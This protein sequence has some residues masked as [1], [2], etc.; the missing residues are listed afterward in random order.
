MNLI[1]ES[2]RINFSANFAKPI[3]KMIKK[4]NVKKECFMKKRVLFLITLMF[5]LFSVNSLF[6][7]RDLN[8]TVVVC[9]STE[10]TPNSTSITWTFTIENLSPDGETITE[11]ILFFPDSITVTSS[12]DFSNVN[13]TPPPPFSLLSQG[14][15]GHSVNVSWSAAGLTSDPIPADSTYEATVTVDIA[16]LNGPLVIPWLLN[17]GGEGIP[18]HSAEGYIVMGPPYAILSFDL[19]TLPT[20]LGGEWIVGDTLC[21]EVLTQGE[22][23]TV[24]VDL[25]EIGGDAALQLD[26][27]PADS[28]LWTG[29]YIITD[30]HDD[31][32]TATITATAYFPAPADLYDTADIVLDIDN[33]L[34]EPITYGY[35]EVLDY[36]T[37]PDSNEIADWNYGNNNDRVRYWRGEENTG[38]GITWT[39][40]EGSALAVD[41][42]V[43]EPATQSHRAVKNGFGP[44]GGINWEMWDPG[45]IVSDNAGNDVIVHVEPDSLILL[46]NMMPINPDTTYFEVGQGPARLVIDPYAGIGDTIT[47]FVDFTTMAPIESGVFDFTPL[48]P[49]SP[50][51]DAAYLIPGIIDGNIM[52][53]EYV[54]QLGDVD[55]LPPTFPMGLIVEATLVDS[56][57]NFS[58][59]P[60]EIGGSTGDTL[61]VDGTIPVALTDI[62]NVGYLRF[63]P[64]TDSSLADYTT[65]T[66]MPDSLILE[67]VFDDW[68]VFGGPDEFVV[69]I[70]QENLANSREANPSALKTYKLGDPDVWIAPITRTAVAVQFSWNG[71]VPVG[72]E[73]GT[74]GQMA[75]EGTYGFTLVSML[76]GA[77]NEGVLGHVADSSDVD[78]AGGIFLLNAEHGV[79]DNTP[80]EYENELAVFGSDDTEVTV[81][82]RWIND[83]NY[84]DS[85]DTGDFLL[86][87]DSVYFQF[88]V[89]RQWEENDNP[90]R[91]ET[92]SYWIELEGPDS[93]KYRYFL[94]DE[95]DFGPTTAQYFGDA[96]TTFT[97]YLTVDDVVFGTFNEINGSVGAGKDIRWWPTLEGGIGNL[98]FPEGLYTITAK[99]RDN[100]GNIRD[101]Q[102]VVRAQV[103][104]IDMLYSAPV[105]DSL[106]IISE[107]TCPD[108]GLAAF[109]LDGN[110]NFYV[111]ASFD[112]LRE[113]YYYNS[114]D[115]FEVYLRLAD[116]T[117]LDSVVVENLYPI[118][119]HGSSRADIINGQLP[120]QVFYPGDFDPTN[121]D[122]TFSYDVAGI[123]ETAAWDSLYTV[124]YLNTAYPGLA[125]QVRVYDSYY[126]GEINFG[127]AL[128]DSFNLIRPEEPVWPGGDSY[129]LEVVLSDDRFSPGWYTHTYDAVDNPARDNEQDQVMI[130]LTYT[131]TE[132]TTRDF[133]WFL[134]I[135]TEPITSMT[136]VAFASAAFTRSGPVAFP[137]TSFSPTTIDFY[138]LANDI[139][140][141]PIIVQD[142]IGKLY[143]TAFALA[144]GYEDCGYDLPPALEMT[145]VIDTLWVDNTN[146][147]IIPVDSDELYDWQGDPN[148]AGHLFI[149]D[150]VVSHDKDNMIFRFR[151]DEPLPDSTLWTAVIVDENGNP[152][153]IDSNT[154]GVTVNEMLS[155]TAIILLQMIKLPTSNLKAIKNWKWMIHNRYSCWW[156]AS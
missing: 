72:S 130:D 91:D 128:A 60:I 118:V 54:V 140:D 74:P 63:S 36:D 77:D 66:N 154:I 57:G 55:Q 7:D 117:Y 94:G 71:I 152:L 144:E 116:I 103:E 104:L 155:D 127:A 27:D 122:L 80:P 86:E 124:G 143:V 135:D 11:V 18:E 81:I 32:P 15:T 75:P 93:T 138:G 65:L 6:A 43:V 25:T 48:N 33:E 85:L 22:A 153:V 131:F 133:T 67:I 109:D 150:M 148:Y 137:V 78:Y 149:E 14:Q 88:D 1:L 37:P 70:E 8:G 76:D 53:A 141:E 49:V 62:H 102:T 31:D 16:G 58:D 13:P 119:T 51:N 90:L 19:V 17:G 145:S 125:F 115:V 84:N 110:H 64:E 114:P 28:T 99:V 134:A 106:V 111:D 12:T 146:P 69:R 34:P 35:F 56:A 123:D 79:I 23:D 121:F 61:F 9:D 73:F 59:P 132:P 24:R 68:G 98:M 120:N 100:A 46:D 44:D 2:F 139:M 101:G 20:G 41:I 89:T 147:G 136:R 4:V 156:S 5:V 21:V 96:L 52:Y 10:Y 126:G 40:P 47:A 45:I 112:T 95:D 129:N 108:T 30:D 39:V 87:V 107:H 26:Q 97:E 50:T 113:D 38:D 105:P 142:S 151:T 42:V 3:K 29:C 82:E 92:V 83:T